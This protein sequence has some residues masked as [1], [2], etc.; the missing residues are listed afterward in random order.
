MR[1]IDAG[2]LQ[3][4][5]PIEAAIDALE[6]AFR[7]ERRP[8]TPLRSH[9]AAPGGE[10][11]L[12]PSAGDPGVGVKLV[13]I[14]PGNPGR[15]LPFLHAVYVLFAPGTL[16]PV[17]VVDGAALTALRTAAVSG[18]ATRHLARAESE[19]LVIFGAGVQA[20]GH[21]L[22]MRAVRPIWHVTV[23][24]RTAPRAEALADRARAL[25]MEAS[26]GGPQTAALAKA[27]LVCTCTT[28]PEPVFDGALLAPGAHVNA[29]GSYQPQTRELDDRAMGRAKI[30]VE[31]R[32]A[33]MAEAGD[34]LIPMRSGAIGAEAVVADLGEV[35]RG[36]TVRTGDG[37]ITVFKS[38]GVAFEDLAVARAAA[39]RLGVR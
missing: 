34:I 7:S 8:E 22:A 32:E 17:A 35:A 14:A 24:S 16:E 2:L 23:V 19:R 15:G 25:G 30:V 1:T 26:A 29:V 27:D 28:S 6:E 3:S 9:V 5:V 36:A 11:L 21:L 12:M 37:D 38:V 13:T 4:L 33:A 10:L 18:L 39:D 20:A 31:T